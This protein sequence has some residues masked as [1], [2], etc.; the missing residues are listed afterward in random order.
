MLTV[1]CIRD[2]DLFSSTLNG[3][4]GL[5]HTV[6]MGHILFADNIAGTQVPHNLQIFFGPLQAKVTIHKIN[7]IVTD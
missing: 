5:S 1:M 3:K 6:N 2:N 4:M 7:N